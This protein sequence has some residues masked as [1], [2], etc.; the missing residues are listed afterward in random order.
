[1]KIMSS[2]RLYVLCIVLLSSL[3]SG[4]VTF[5]GDSTFVRHQDV[6]YGY[7]YGMALIMDVFSP[8]NPNG[9]GVIW[10][11]SGSGQSSRDKIKE[12]RFAGFLDKGYCV[13]VVMH[14]SEPRFNLQDMVAD[15]YLAVRYIRFH[16]A[17]YQIDGER[18]GIMGASAG[19]YLALMAG[20]NGDS[21]CADSND[22]VQQTPNKVKAVACFFSPTDWL[23]FGEKGMNFIDFQLEHYGKIGPSFVFYGDKKGEGQYKPVEDREQILA[24]LKELSPI[25]HVSKDDPATLIIHGELDPFIPFQ[26]G[27]SLY[28]QL[29]EAGVE[30]QFIL[31]KGKTHGW[32]GWEEDIKLVVDWFDKHL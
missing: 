30:T 13:F 23:N 3:T 9:K 11:I 29:K 2:I 1:M 28:N 32:K 31:R 20:L 25:T 16:A 17:D 5:A 4:S 6:I 19:G 14:S 21:G 24:I 18:L 12:Q 15:V 27:E 10:I 22:P 8:K 7:K 26:Q